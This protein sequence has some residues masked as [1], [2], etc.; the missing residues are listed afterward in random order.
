MQVAQLWRYPVKSLQGEPLEL[1]AVTTVGVEGDRHF[2]LFDVNTGY[3]LTRDG[4]PSCCS[5]QPGS[6]TM[7]V[8][9]SPCPTAR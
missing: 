7:A 4:S 1:A 8:S 5:L 2:A 3:G 6:A 9:T